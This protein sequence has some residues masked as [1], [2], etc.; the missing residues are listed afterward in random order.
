LMRRSSGGTT[1][2]SHGMRTPRA[3]AKRMRASRSSPIHSPM[4]LV[5]RPSCQSERDGAKVIGSDE[6]GEAERVGAAPEPAPGLLA[7]AQVV[8]LGARGDGR[9]V[10]VGASRAEASRY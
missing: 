1:S 3:R 5:K 8:V 2:V 6:G 9:E 10:V 4:T 7:L